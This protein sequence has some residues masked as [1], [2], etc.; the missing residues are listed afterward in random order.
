[1]S[2]EIL[3][4]TPAIEDTATAAA[5]ASYV[6]RRWPR[7]L[8]PAIGLAI[9][10]SLAPLGAVLG[11][12][13][14]TTLTVALFYVVV[15]QGWNLL[16][17]FAGYINFGVALFTGA[18]IYAAAMLNN[19]LGWNMWATIVPA[20]LVAMAVSAVVGLATLRLRSHYFS[21]FTLILVFLAIVIVNNSPALGG[22]IGLVTD[23]EGEWTSRSLAQFFYYSF[24]GLA[25]LATLVAYFVANSNLGNALRSVRED[26]SAARVLGVRTTD[27]KFRALLIGAG[28]GGA[29]GA[30]FAFFTPYIEPSGTFDLA[31]SL[32]IVLVCVV[33]GLGTWIGP[34]IGS[35]LVVLLEQWL[36]T[37]ILDLH[38]FGMDIPPDAN[39]LVLGVVLIL[40]ALF[41]RRGIVG[42]AQR[43]SG[44]RMGV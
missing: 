14:E 7:W 44:R 23:V 34:L 30:M 40:F 10:A 8:A 35:I 39:R 32:D 43:R 27:V 20:A 41:A 24:F 22:A 13:T 37:L 9:F 36:R 6:A 11:L 18:G 28:L 15:A 2:N 29:A 5:R 42:L 12:G 38:P 25:V 4:T 21:I 1:M 33:G 3:N 19:S 31:F 26:E 16:G 17:G